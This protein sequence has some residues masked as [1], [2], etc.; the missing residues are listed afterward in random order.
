[1]TVYYI[2]RHMIEVPLAPRNVLK[3]DQQNLPEELP[4]ESPLNE[5]TPID[6]LFG[7]DFS[8]ALNDFRYAYDTS[9][10]YGYSGDDESA[11]APDSF[12]AD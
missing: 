11:I 3:S 5:G 6:G 10:C 2:A 7:E 12:W 4:V 8:P 1:M 9:C